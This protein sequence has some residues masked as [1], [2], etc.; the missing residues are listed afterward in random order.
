MRKALVPIAMALL[1]LVGC[2]PEGVVRGAAL[3]PAAGPMFDAHAGELRVVFSHASTG[4]GTLS[5]TMPDRENV[6][7]QYR[8]LDRFSMDAAEGS[9]DPGRGQVVITPAEWKALYGQSDM[10]S[11]QINGEALCRGDRGTVLRVQYVVDPFDNTGFGVAKDNRGNL[12][13]LRF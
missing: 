2:I 1:A 10:V 6:S 11:G 12:Y 9:G 4:R 5:V 8:T 7:G 13:R 3:M